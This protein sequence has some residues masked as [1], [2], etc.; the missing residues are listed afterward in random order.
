[1]TETKLST[2]EDYC[3]WAAI[4]SLALHRLYAEWQSQGYA[5]PRV[6][7]GSAE[8]VPDTFSTKSFNPDPM[9]YFARQ[10]FYFIEFGVDYFICIFSPHNKLW[11]AVS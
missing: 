1:V 2:V 10:S 9:R 6:S 8:S 5:V 11:N 3:P 4:A 7:T